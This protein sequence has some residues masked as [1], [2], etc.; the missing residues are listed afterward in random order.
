MEMGNHVQQH[1]VATMRLMS[2]AEKENIQ[3]QA[4]KETGKRKAEP[5]GTEEERTRKGSDTHHGGVP[6]RTQ[7]STEEVGQRGPF[8]GEG[9]TRC[10]HVLYGLCTGHASIAASPVAGASTRSCSWFPSCGG[11][12][13]ELAGSSLILVVAPA[14]TG[15]VLGETTPCDKIRGLITWRTTDGIR[16]AHGDASTENKKIRQSKMLT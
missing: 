16:T 7:S 5:L 6:N 2:S 8:V 13:F 9:T 10:V 12:R 14:R 1:C 15:L 3:Q 4:T 11:P